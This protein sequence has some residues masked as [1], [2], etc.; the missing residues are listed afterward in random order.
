MRRCCIC[1]RLVG[2]Y[3]YCNSNHKVLYLLAACQKYEMTLV[4]SFIR[5][6]VSRG[7]SPVPKGAE[8]FTAYAIASANEL[9]PEMEI[10]AHLTLDHPMTFETLG[11]GL[12]FFE[13]WALRDLVKF[14]RRCRDNLLTCLEPFFKPSGPSS[15]WIGCPEVYPLPRWLNQV[16]TRNQH[17]LKTQIFTYPLDIC[18]RIRGEYLKA[19]QT[20]LDC[21]FCLGV[22]ASK[23]SAFCTELENKLAQARDKV[24]YSHYVS[25]ITRFNS[26]RYAIIAVLSLVCLTRALGIDEAS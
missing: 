6:E 1:L 10:A 26:R 15:I 5:A 4:Q 13:G 18:K 21:K 20:H 7:A 25:S 22:H 11:E 17:D 2:S 19:L 9:I 16:L 12:R 8:T 24:T 14:R 23:G 3:T